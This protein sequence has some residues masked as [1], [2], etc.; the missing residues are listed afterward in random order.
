MVRFYLVPV[1]TNAAGNSRGP[2]Y[3]PFRGDPN[4]PALI[5]RDWEARDYGNEPSMVLAAD[6]NDAEDAL[7]ASQPD[8]TKFADDLDTPI[9]AGLAAM[10]AAL[11]AL[12]LPANAITAGTTHRQVLRGVLGIFAIAQCMQ[13]KGFR[14][15]GGALTL[16][17]TLG[18][19]SV[20]ARQ[21]LSSCAVTLGYDTSGTTLATTLRQVLVMIA[22]Q[23]NPTPMM[24]VSL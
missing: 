22:N 20:A 19:L 4:P 18:D 9:G 8:V 15:F 10:Q 23:T 5:A 24:G 16:T 7:L 14:V 1:E 13:G 6:L 11:E 12:N 3:F 17:S 2:K 21:A